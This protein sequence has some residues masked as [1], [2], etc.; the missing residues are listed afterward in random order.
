M[1]KSFFAGR[2]G[3]E[4]IIRQLAAGANDADP[5]LNHIIFDSRGYP[6]RVL[7]SGEFLASGSTWQLVGIGA[8]GA[9]AGN[10]SSAHGLSSIPTHVVATAR[11]EVESSGAPAQ[12]VGRGGGRA[13]STPMGEGS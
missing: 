5:A 1:P 12:A 10:T 4:F 8:Y 9:V 7:G 13:S 11:P 6:G 3:S 2:S